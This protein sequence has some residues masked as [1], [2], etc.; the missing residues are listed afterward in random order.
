MSN[1]VKAKPERRTRSATKP[2][3]SAPAWVWPALLGGAIVLAVVVGVV[4]FA[5]G[6]DEPPETV[7]VNGVP[8]PDYDG[9]GVD[10]AV[11]VKAPVFQAAP[12]GGTRRTVGSGGGPNDPTRV[13]VFVSHWCEGCDDAVQDAAALV[14]GGGVP[15]GTV[16]EIIPTDDDPERANH[17]AERWLRD[18]GWTGTAYPDSGRNTLANAYGIVDLPTWV[19]LDTKNVVITREVGSA[20]LT[21]LV[22]QASA[23]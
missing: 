17:P 2:L 12:I 21:A 18:L 14:G 19:V 22:Q 9:V 13:Y 3:S 16:V 23:G 4:L 6:E 10:S 5:G 1:R 7:R 20:D 11:G 8:L 15:A